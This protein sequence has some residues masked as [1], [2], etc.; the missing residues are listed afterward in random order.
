M[1]RLEKLAI[2]AKGL[3][4]INR[5]KVVAFIDRYKE[6]CV[7][8]VSDTLGFSQPLTS[9]Y[10]KQLKDAG[11]VKSRK[12]GKWSIF[13]IADNYLIQPF[14]E[15]LRKVEIPNIKKCIRC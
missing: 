14:L 7:C 11:I 13:S 8:E 3:S 6:V 9:K 10:L 4:D 2:V 1:D 5:L 15:E 12:S